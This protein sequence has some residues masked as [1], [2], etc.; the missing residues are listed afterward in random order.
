MKRGHIYVHE[1]R[2]LTRTTIA[3]YAFHDSGSNAPVKTESDFGLTFE[4]MFLGH[5]FVL[6][7]LYEM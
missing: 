4:R 2:K 7:Q 5:R 1:K 3:C 6:I